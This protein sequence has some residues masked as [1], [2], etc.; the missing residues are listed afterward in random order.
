[1][2]RLLPEKSEYKGFK[3]A[4]GTVAARIEDSSENGPQPIK[5]FALYLNLCSLPLT[6]PFDIVKDVKRESIS[7]PMID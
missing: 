1:M 3:G 4:L 5:F 2:K 7:N 6:I